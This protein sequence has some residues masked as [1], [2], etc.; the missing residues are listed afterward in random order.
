MVKITMWMVRSR[1]CWINITKIGTITR[2]LSMKIL[3]LR[4][5]PASKP[6]RNAIE[7]VRNMQKMP[8]K[9]AFKN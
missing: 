7:C 3:P 8:L 9:P 2:S 1:E 4:N 5:S 6:L